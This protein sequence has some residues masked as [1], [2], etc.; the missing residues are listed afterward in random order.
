M[1]TEVA[2]DQG[3]VKTLLDLIGL[4]A[5]AMA[6]A[7]GILARRDKRQFVQ[8]LDAAVPRHE[9]NETV[10]A[11]RR[12][13]RDDTETLRQELRESTRGTH[14]RLDQLMLL[15]AKNGG[16]HGTD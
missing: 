6:T 9:F 7:V 8:T 15:M 16:Q 11:L 10:N 5:M 2:T 14:Q 4:L 12:E 3:I 13:M 1:A